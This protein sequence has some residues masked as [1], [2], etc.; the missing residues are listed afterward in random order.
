M[1]TL[2]DYGEMIADRVRIDAY[3]EALRR[4][5]RPGAVVVDLGTGPG[6]MAVL[7]C[8]LGAGRVY[9][10]ERETIIQVGRE[11][12]A[13][14]HCADKIEFI[15][16]LSTKVALPV[17]ADVMVS[18]IRGVLP[19]FEHHIGV[20]ADA[21]RRF[22]APDGI[23]IPRKDTIWASVVE[24]PECYSKILGPWD[25]NVLGQNLNPVRRMILNDFQKTYL[26]PQQLLTRPQRWTTLDY[27]SVENPDVQSELNWNVERD[28]IGHGM[29]AW[30]DAELADGVGFSNAPGMPK[31]IYQSLFFPWLNP[32]PL[33]A[34]QIV[35]VDLQA[36]LLEEDY[37][38]RWTTQVE[39]AERPGEIAVLF[40]QSQ[41]QGSV[42]PPAKLHKSAS[43]Y[44]PQL[45]EEGLVRRRTLE[46]MDGRASLEEIARQLTMEFPERFVRWQQALTFA[47]AISNEN[48]R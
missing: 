15:E 39:S 6:I 44:I 4:A 10:I 16:E 1:Y 20:I 3:R 45:S 14:N 41:L 34:G 28:G 47:S 42:L 33:A 46:L 29:L 38:W 48:S 32:V 24:A 19:L 8:Q 26:S 11:V 43:D 40:E 36:K 37:F 18:D 2:A 25:C 21:R 12:A 13:A 31:T 30:F 5:I 7:A 17:R 35:R 22:L 9:A 27:T 23:L